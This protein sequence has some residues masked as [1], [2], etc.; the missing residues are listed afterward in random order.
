MNYFRKVT[1]TATPGISS[2]TG[3]QKVYTTSVTDVPKTTLTPLFP[4]VV[5]VASG[6][7]AIYYVVKNGWCNVNFKFN[8]TSSTTF[9]WTDIAWGLPI[10]ANSIDTVLMSDGKA[11]QPIPIKITST[12]S[13]SSKVLSAI[14][15][16]DWWT[17]NISYPVAE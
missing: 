5:K 8:I 17:G 4:S 9:S 1:S 7:V 16:T 3:W 12:G 10:P 2:D 14:S 11:T 15:T 6:G 13:V